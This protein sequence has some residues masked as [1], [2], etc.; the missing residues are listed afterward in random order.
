MFLDTVGLL[1]LWDRADNWH[2]QAERAFKDLQA[3]RLD[4]V[5]TT[6]ILAEC[7]NAAAGKPYRNAVAQ[8]RRRM[9]AGGRTIIPTAEDWQ[10]AWQQYEQGIAGSA[11]IVDQISLVVARRLGI[12][13][14]FSNDKH[15]AAA[16]FEV[17]F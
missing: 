3:Q 4:C 9:E 1:A 5:T 13:Q 10:L 2:E 8:L 12:H 16:G 14:V 11:G 15:F 7:G 17:L 6:F